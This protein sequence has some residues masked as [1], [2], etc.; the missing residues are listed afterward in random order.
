MRNIILL[1]RLLV[2]FF[3]LLPAYENIFQAASKVGYA[4]AKGVPFPEFLVPFSGLLLLI[5]GLSILTGYQT[6]IGVA[7]LVLF[8]I[9]VTLMTHAFWTIQDP[10]M[11][12]IEFH[13][14][15]SNV[16]LLGSALLFLAIPTTWTVP[17]TL[18]PMRMA[19]AND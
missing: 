8:F 12:M 7:A 18:L 17:A 1:G 19:Q 6:K 11:R 5:G 3:Y 13:S 9:P 14:F 2:G 15:L 16:G 10:M 4:A